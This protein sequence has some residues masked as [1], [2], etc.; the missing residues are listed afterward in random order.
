MDTRV[1]VNE[2]STVHTMI[3]GTTPSLLP[4][5][6]IL[7]G[8]TKSSETMSLLDLWMFEAPLATPLM[9]LLVTKEAEWSSSVDL[10]SARTVGVLLG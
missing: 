7:G 3:N 2:F 9:L 1:N 6:P 5:T 4:E 10:R 8:Y